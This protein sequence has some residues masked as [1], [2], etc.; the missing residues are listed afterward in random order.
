VLRLTSRYTITP[1]P[2]SAS[3][4]FRLSSSSSEPTLLLL[5]LKL[6]LLKIIA[7]LT[8]QRLTSPRRIPPF[9]VLKHSVHAMVTCNTDSLCDKHSAYMC[10]ASLP[11][12]TNT[13]IYTHVNTQVR[14]H[15]L[16]RY[17]SC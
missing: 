16:P 7:M 15:A 6:I 5:Y 10:T 17:M 4:D 9:F 13:H 8:S 1:M 12:H 11:V 2:M 14:Q 3:V